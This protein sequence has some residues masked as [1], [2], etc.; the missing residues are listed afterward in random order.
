MHSLQDR[1]QQ[2][3]GLARQETVFKTSL[4]P[5]VFLFVLCQLFSLKHHSPS[6]RFKSKCKVSSGPDWLKWQ[7]VKPSPC[8]FFSSENK[9]LDWSPREAKQLKRT[10][11][12]FYV[13]STAGYICASSFPVM[14]VFQESTLGATARSETT[15]T[16]FAHFEVS[17]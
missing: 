17:R 14:Q 2:I 4:L 7:L 13:H 15:H 6:S 16:N 10:A 11:V 1:L 8:I 9:C 3:E 12:Q 5:F